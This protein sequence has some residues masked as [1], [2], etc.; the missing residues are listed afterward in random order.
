MILLKLIFWLC[1]LVI[2][3]TYVGYPIFLYLIAKIRKRT[4]KKSPISP[5]VSLIIAAYNEEKAIEAKI[6]NSLHLDYPCSAME[7]IIASDGSTDR[8]DKIVQKYTPKGVKLLCLP[9]KGKL[10]ALDAAVACS[11]NEILVFSDANTIYDPQA[12]KKLVANFADSEVGG[13]CGNMRYLKSVNTDNTSKGEHF[14]WKY[15]KWLKSMESVV[16]SIV[17][18]D[19]AIYAIRRALYR[20]PATDNVIDDFAI[21]TAVIEQGYR[22]V[23]EKEAIGYE[24]PMPR[25]EIEFSRKL[26]IIN[27][28]FMSLLLRK[29]LFNPFRYGLYSLILLS[30]KLLRRLIPFFL[31]SLLI[32]SWLLKI[33][34]D[35]YLQTAFLQIIFYF[36]AFISFLVRKTQIGKWKIFYLPFFF[37]LANAA[38]LWAILNLIAGKRVRLWNPS[39]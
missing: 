3:Y 22:L 36:W 30:H 23:F 34:G 15:D 1:V 13:V 25:A 6:Q 4:V 38:A 35:F 26:R 11:N 37:C 14:Y 5:S 19:G 17:G 24:E 20:K 28:G 7:I 31:L 2:L 16:E 9:R 12:V 39:R 18:A 29:N 10:N 8:T 27:G 21:S 33:E 32:S